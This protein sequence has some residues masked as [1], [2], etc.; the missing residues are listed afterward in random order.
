MVLAILVKLGL[1]QI[2]MPVLVGY[3]VLGVLLRIA[4]QE[5]NLLSE[6]GKEIF[7]FLADIGIICLLF[8]VGLE[9]RLTELI[10]Q[11]RRASLIWAGNVL[12]SG[13]LGFFTTYSL[14]NL[15]LI[16]S[17]FVGTAMTATSVAIS[18]GVWREA[19]ATNSPNGE[20]LLDVVEMGDISGV[21][22][23]AVLL[24]VA[25]VLRDGTETT[26]LMVLPKTAGLF[27]LKALL[28]GAFCF[29]FSRYVEQ[30][31]TSFFQKLESPPNTALVVAS[32]GF[33]IAAL[34][35]LL[36]F[37][38]AIGAFFAGLVFSRDPQSLKLDDSLNILYG[39]FVP[40][41]FIGIGLKVNPN[42]LVTAFS[43]GIILLFVAVIGKVVGAAAPVLIIAGWTDAVLFGVS[44]V[45]RSEITMVVMQHGLQLGNWAVP[46]QMFAAMVVVS[47]GTSIIAPLVLH[48]LLQRW[49]QRQEQP[50]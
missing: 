28:F 11:L 19:D 45:P 31:I 30:S 16:P 40:F 35:G 47:A 26:L 12:V 6:A 13:L 39:L 17:L 38:I 49:P 48:P 21:I 3:L 20:L 23:M 9:S 27:F 46:P 41:F 25:P 5:F 15:E 14:L 42:L 36:G 29:L 43:L 1:E 37:S 2:G 34:A 50:S 10:R 33:I 18:T 32:I 24:A 44:M 7:E 4:D 22:L 8:R